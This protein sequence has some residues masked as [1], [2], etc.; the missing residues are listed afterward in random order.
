MNKKILILLLILI[1]AKLSHAQQWQ[2]GQFVGFDWI[3]YKYQ[4]S[5]SI[6]PYNVYKIDPSFLSNLGYVNELKFFGF[7][8]NYIRN[9]KWHYGLNFFRNR[10]GGDR[11]GFQLIKDGPS[12]AYN[13]TS[14]NV[15]AHIAYCIHRIKNF[16]FILKSGLSAQ[17]PDRILFNDQGQSRYFGLQATNKV[18]TVTF[19]E[20]LNKFNRVLI[21]I[22]L[23][24]SF[25]ENVY[26]NQL[27]LDLTLAYNVGIYAKHEYSITYK[28][29][30]QPIETATVK[31][32]HNAIIASL[33]VQWRFRNKKREN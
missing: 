29:N 9:D 17:I 28:I 26:K 20:G 14:S 6:I 19:L 16:S 33:G 23:V 3:K 7:S 2:V 22:P 4:H 11:F 32:N 13:V 27:F 10:D 25:Q 18:D 1:I 15:S 12:T 30:S 24:L 31:T 8:V 21:T 5:P